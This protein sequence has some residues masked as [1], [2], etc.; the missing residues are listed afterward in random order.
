M[1]RFKKAFTFAIIVCVI[2]HVIGLL[3]AI[4]ISGLEEA[5]VDFQYLGPIT[6]SHFLFPCFLAVCFYENAIFSNWLNVLNV[7]LKPAFISFILLYLIVL[8]ILSVKKDIVIPFWNIASFFNGI[9][10]FFIAIFSSFIYYVLTNKSKEQKVNTNI[11]F[12]LGIVIF[13]GLVSGIIYTPVLY[14]LGGHLK[15]INA[16]F[17][18]LFSGLFAALIA[19]AIFRILQNRKLNSTQR[20]LMIFGLYLFNTL[21]YPQL[22]LFMFFPA[23]VSV[24]FIKIIQSLIVI[25]PFYFFITLSIHAYYIFMRNKAEKEFLAQQGVSANLKFQQLKA[26]LSPHFLFNN[27]SVLT[28]LIEENP[29]KAV[30]FS[31]NLSDVYRYFLDQE[32]QDL[33]TLEDELKFANYYLDLLKIRCEDALNVTFELNNNTDE[34][35][36]LPLALQQVFENIVKHNEI[37]ISKPME[38][39]VTIED[40]FL[41]ITNSVN[42]KKVSNSQ[43]KTGI[44]NVRNR[45]SYFTNQVILITS[46]NEFYSIKLPLLKTE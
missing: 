31:Q 43:V 33:V 23:D 30:Q 7:L 12:S 18:I 39:I 27:L 22:G 37:S 17:S 19:Y 10:A 11:K 25:S 38:I 15:S 32:H 44:E 46:N 45:Y 42:L 21:I 40:Y 24:K 9:V 4:S 8:I 2:F 3:I 13:L 26:Q 29:E 16:M 34:F 14:F 1:K 5:W 28:A 6:I 36:I 20:N 41:V 35:Y